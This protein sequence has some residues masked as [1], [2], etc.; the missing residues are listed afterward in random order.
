MKN[1][2]LICGLMISVSFGASALD[3]KQRFDHLDK[4]KDGFLIKSELDPQ[5]QLL[6][7]YQRWDKDRDNRISLL[8]FKHYLTNSLY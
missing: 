4:D 7:D 1:T 8:E 3:V 5:P 6:N 2:A